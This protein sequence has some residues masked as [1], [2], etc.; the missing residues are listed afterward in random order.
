VPLFINSCFYD[1]YNINIK[2]LIAHYWAVCSLL[3]LEKGK[4]EIGFDF[5]SQKP[6]K[7]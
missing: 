3:F 7:P 4:N 2:A 1:D 6:Q 5:I